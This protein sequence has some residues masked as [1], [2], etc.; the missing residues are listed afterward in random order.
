MVGATRGFPEEVPRSGEGAPGIPG[1][2]LCRVYICSAAHCI[3]TRPL[4]ASV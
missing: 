4:R 1:L 2:W 3:V